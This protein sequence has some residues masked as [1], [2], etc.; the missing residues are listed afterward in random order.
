MDNV[1]GVR[2]LCQQISGE[3]D[4][5][6][7]LKLLDQLSYELEKRKTMQSAKEQYHPIEGHG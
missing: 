6:R 3:K 7:L 5:R 4:E 2:E 1:D